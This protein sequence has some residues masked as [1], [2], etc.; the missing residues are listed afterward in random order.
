MLPWYSWSN[1]PIF[2]WAR[3]GDLHL[4]YAWPHAFVLCA[5]TA[6]FAAILYGIEKD[7]TAKRA[8]PVAYIDALFMATSASTVTGLITSPPQYMKAG[9]NV[10]LLLLMVIGD[11]AFTSLMLCV[12]RRLHLAQLMALPRLTEAAKKELLLERLAFTKL[13]IIVP[14]LIFGFIG[15]GTIVM[16]SYLTYHRPEISGD[17][18]PFWFALYTSVRAPPTQPPPL[19]PSRPFRVCV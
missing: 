15:A 14:C 1:L 3:W 11:A 16:G 4:G 5:L 17:Q 12:L 9:S 2:S 13:L 19:P 7:G 10:I 18:T 8:G 6:I